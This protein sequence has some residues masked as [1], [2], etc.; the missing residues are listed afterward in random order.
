MLGWLKNVLSARGETGQRAN[1]GDTAGGARASGGSVGEYEEQIGRGNRLLDQGRPKEAADAYRQ[2][3]SLRPDDAIPRVNLSFA[4]MEQ[5]LLDDARLSLEQAVRLEP[6]NADALYM[7]GTISASRG[8]FDQAIDLF[9]KV[10]ETKPDFEIVYGE[11]CRALFQAGRL[12]DA[13]S[14]ARKGI[15]LF[16]ETAA[17]HCYLGNLLV[18][19]KD[20][21]N[22]IPCFRKALSIQ[23]GYVE[24]Y[25]G[26]GLALRGNKQL[27]E[28]VESCRRAIAIKPD[29]AD[30]HYNLGLVLKNQGLLDDAIRCYRTAL[31]LNPVFAEAY[32]DLGLALKEQGKLEEAAESCR[33]ALTLKPG[34]A[35]AYRNLGLIFQEQGKQDVAVE[36]YLKAIS[37]EPNSA[38]AHNNL[39]CSLQKQGKLDAAIDRYRQA[40]SLEPDSV[41]I[42]NNFGSALQLQGNLDEAIEYFHKALLLEP[43]CIEARS[44]LLFVLSYHAGHGAAEYLEEALLYGKTLGAS[45]RPYAAWKTGQDSPDVQPLRIGL[46]SGDLRNHPAGFFLESILQHLDPARVELVAYPTQSLEDDLTARIKPR[47][48]AWHSLVGLNDEAAAKRIHE[49]GIHVL[50]DLAGHTAH[51][52]LPVFA[53]KPAPVQVTWLGY[54]ASTGVAE[55]DYLLADSVSVPAAEQARFTEKIWYL[56]DTRLCFTPPAENPGLAANTLPA[57]RNGYITFGCFQNLTKI[58]DAVLAAWGRIFQALPNARLRLQNKQLNSHAMRNAILQRLHRVGIATSRVMVHGQSPREAYLAAHAEVDIIL[59]TFPYPGGTT[60]CEALWMGVPTLTLAGDS[61]I[62]R[63]GAGMLSCAGLLDW[64]ARDTDDYVGL[65]LRHAADLD[66]LAKLRLGLRQKVLASPLFDA[67]RFAANLETALHDMWRKR[68]GRDPGTA[69]A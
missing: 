4:L 19:E 40:L 43:G 52:R 29:S 30:A 6:S 21:A 33:H 65:A 23:P 12:D 37:I 55:I 35:E 24:A 1:S 64:V 36:Y 44:N 57:L 22:A 41:E 66:G 47:F 32:N 39:A 13:R 59:D 18:A 45:A 67:P 25:S 10:L 11:L 48:A 61:L 38:L 17:L 2:A 60:T 8:Q 50:I 31:A 20:F 63:Q 28:A 14:V 46:V 16:P 58:N 62:E 56:P 27:E 34:H 69:W 7:L 53:W 26:M 51:N 54:F 49:D 42:H 68:P 3:V 9:S 5:G 15:G